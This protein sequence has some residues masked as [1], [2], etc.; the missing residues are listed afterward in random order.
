MG[1]GKKP[2]I[3]NDPPIKYKDGYK[4][5]LTEKWTC[6]LKGY[7]FSSKQKYLKLGFLQFKPAKKSDETKSVCLIENKNSKKDSK[8]HSYCLIIEKGY[9]WDGASGPTP[10]VNPHKIMRGSLVHDAL[11]QLMR[12][13]TLNHEKDRS[14]ADQ[15]LY[16]FC[17]QDGM[18]KVTAECVHNAV[19]L[20]GAWYA[21]PS[22]RK[23]E[24]EAPPS[25]GSSESDWEGDYDEW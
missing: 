22:T 7:S 19:Q 6:I 2:T 11:Y 14:T 4:Y 17:I 23:E 18:L 16:D 13:G 3:K 20:F 5:Q 10:G 9:A 12:H 24:R 8:N 1:R 21:D 25:N 15:I